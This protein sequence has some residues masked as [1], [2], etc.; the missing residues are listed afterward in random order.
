[1]SGPYKYVLKQGSGVSENFILQ[2]VTPHIGGKLG[3]NVA[4]LLHYYIMRF[5]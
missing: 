3:N 4:N 2:Y 1:M 5:L